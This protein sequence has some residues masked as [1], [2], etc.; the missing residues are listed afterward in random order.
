MVPH[1]SR[2]GQDVANIPLLDRSSPE[3]KQAYQFDNFQ[4][5]KLT[6]QRL[7]DNVQSMDR[8]KNIQMSLRESVGLV[9]V[10]VSVILLPFGYWVHRVWF[11]ADIVLACVGGPL[12]F[13]GR[14]SR[15][16]LRTP[17]LPD[18]LN[19][20]LV[21]DQLRGFPGHRVTESHNSELEID[22]DGERL[23]VFQKCRMVKSVVRQGRS[24]RE[25]EAYCLVR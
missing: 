22:G 21:P 9:F 5:L 1:R 4:L 15:K 11:V 10:F 8:S 6:V 19:P 18:H 3:P 17:D 23:P 7:S 12:F 20:P 13:T 14:M 24:E 16:A 2:G 25:P